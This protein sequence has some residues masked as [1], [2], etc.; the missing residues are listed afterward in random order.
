MISF[1]SIA[2]IVTA[3]LIAGLFFGFSTAINPAF[4]K[5]DNLAYIKAM[6]G[7]NE[8]ILNPVFLSCFVL[9][10]IL[11]PLSAWL[12]FKAG[13][14]LGGI[15]F[16]VAALIYIIGVFGLTAVVNV[17]LNNQLAAYNTGAMTGE[18]LAVARDHFAIPWNQAHTWRTVLSVICFAISVVALYIGKSR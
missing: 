6:Q 4:L 5:L 2:A 10:C 18:Q 3:G 9:P 1:S 11:L 8:R 12:H 14:G 16:A 15:L 7:I 17:P 13:A